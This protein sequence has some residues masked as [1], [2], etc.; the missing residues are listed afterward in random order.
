[1]LNK[2]G[3][4]KDIQE[5]LKKVYLEQAKLATEGDE[6]ES[7]EDALERITQKMAEV[8]SDAVDRY[9]KT[10]DIIV[11]NK[12]ISVLTSSGPAQVIPLTPANLQ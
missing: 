6:N 8:I 7:P 12:V 5:G 9:V 11:D 10:G 1:M 3:L 2:K 4:Q